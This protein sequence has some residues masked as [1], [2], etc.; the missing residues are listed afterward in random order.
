MPLSSLG[1]SRVDTRVLMYSI[2]AKPNPVVKRNDTKKKRSKKKK[3]RK[4][5][6]LV[7]K[8]I[9]ESQTQF[10]HG[11]LIKVLTFRYRAAC[12]HIFIGTTAFISGS[13]SKQLQIWCILFKH[14]W[15][16]WQSFIVIMNMG[17]VLAHKVYR[18]S[19]GAERINSNAVVW[20]LCYVLETKKR[21]LILCSCPW[22]FFYET[23]QF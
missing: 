21:A 22:L 19:F 14:G 4:A 3:K 20:W 17:L 5:C 11:H 8:L 9:L 1:A 12:L 2:N 7:Q 10:C 15:E 23:F 18:P 6:E 13:S 16:M